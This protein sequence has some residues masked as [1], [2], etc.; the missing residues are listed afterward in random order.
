MQL[1]NSWASGYFQMVCFCTGWLY[2]SVTCGWGEL[3]RKEGVFIIAQG[4]R[5]FSLGWPGPLSLWEHSTSLQGYKMMRGP[6][7]IMAESKQRVGSR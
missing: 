1:T 5:A 3:T 4:F 2:I 6:A 7:H